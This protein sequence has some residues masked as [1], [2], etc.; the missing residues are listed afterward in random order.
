MIRKLKRNNYTDDSALLAGMPI[1]DLKQAVLFFKQKNNNTT[2]E[3]RQ[4][5]T[6]K[7]SI[8]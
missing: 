7:E 6:R 2:N 1:P 3:K 5:E 4:K 8:R